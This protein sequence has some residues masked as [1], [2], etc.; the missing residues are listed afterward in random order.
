MGHAVQVVDIAMRAA[1]KVR[2]PSITKGLLKFL[3]E[4][5]S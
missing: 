3:E 5:R 1:C 4:E 2:A